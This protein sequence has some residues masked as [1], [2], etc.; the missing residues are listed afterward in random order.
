M[1]DGDPQPDPNA[2]PAPGY[3]MPG[4]PPPGYV[5]PGY[6]P[7]GYAP[8][9]YLPP[10]YPPP[11]YPPPGYAP[12]GF[13]PA[14]YPGYPPPGYPPPG[15][16]PPGY[17]PWGF[18]PPVPGSGRFRAQSIGELLDS[19]FTMYRRKFLLIVAITAMLQLPYIVIQ[20]LLIR[21]F[22]GS[23]LSTALGAG[24]SG[25]ASRQEQTQSV[26]NLLLVSLGILGAGLVY[27]LV[28]QPIVQ[29]ATVRVV[30]ADYL[31]RPTSFGDAL[32][33]ALRRF[34]ALL[35]FGVLNLLILV[36]PGAVLFGLAFAANAPALLVL[37]VLL[38]FVYFIFVSIRLQLS[39][40]AIV[41][42]SGGPTVGI[43]RS[44]RLTEG[45]FWRIVGLNVIIA[46]VSYVLSLILQTLIGAI[47]GGVDPVTK[48]LVN[49]AASSA[50]GIFTTPLLLIVL[51]LTYY[52]I[53]IRREAFDLE[54]LAGSL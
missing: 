50:I 32:R 43:A 31:D 49:S 5:P 13:G 36:V 14:G 45:S 9:G 26:L 18:A 10:G 15:Y 24:G 6:P 52:D 34:A 20:L 51:T 46:V 8:P 12:P 54:M 30:S 23:A 3:P 22:F 21:T 44:W 42:E 27:A 35:G 41:L 19:A 48:L 17:P 37:F 38:W 1:A 53:R 2:P 4:I 47:F 16:P 25:F 28:L 33:H 39:V 40:P 11:G 7:P 29:A